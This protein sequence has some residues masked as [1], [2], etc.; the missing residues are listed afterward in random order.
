MLLSF[1][2]AALVVGLSAQVETP[3]IDIRC[4][5]RAQVQPLTTTDTS[6]GRR[7]TWRPREAIALVDSY[8]RSGW[9][10]D[11]GEIRLDRVF[12]L[13]VS[14]DD[15]DGTIE[16]DRDFGYF[17]EGDRRP[18]STRL[19]PDKIEFSVRS[20]AGPLM[21]NRRNG[22]LNLVIEEDDI[23]EGPV[24]EDATVRIEVTGRCQE[25]QPEDRLF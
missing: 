3:T 25:F 15:G 6:T 24:P 19:Y 23:R 7:R 5:M 1:A 16:F 10:F 13:S 4:E 20:G 8:S 18:I 9:G 11:D 22:R 2:A 17:N 21:I 12:Y 14:S